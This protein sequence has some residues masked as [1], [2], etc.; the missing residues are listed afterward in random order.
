MIIKSNSN[1]GVWTYMNSEYQKQNKS[2]KH[3][4]KDDKT[5]LNI[6]QEQ[7]GDCS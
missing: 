1:F 3:T 7:V 2:Y 4:I 5:V 6:I